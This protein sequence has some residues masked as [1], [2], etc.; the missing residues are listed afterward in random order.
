MWQ[1]LTL[2]SIFLTTSENIIDKVVMVTDKAMDTLLASFYRNGLVF[3]FSVALA[4]TGIFGQLHIFLNWVV[5]LL[6]VL[7]IGQGIFYTYLLKHIELTGSSA[8]SYITPFFFL[9]VD[10][11]ALK[12]P[13]TLLQMGGVVLLVLGGMIFAIS[14]ENWRFKPEYTKYVL[15]I[16]A[17][18]AVFDGCEYYAFKHYHAALGINEISWMASVW[19]LVTA[20][21]IILI[22]LKRGWS[23]WRYTAVHNSY[24]AKEGV[25]KFLDALAY[26]LWLRALTLTNV[27]RVNAL[28]SFEP[29]MLLVMLYATQKLLRK[30][31]DEN[32]DGR[33]LWQK[34]FA[35]AVLILGAL[36]AS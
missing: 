12:A 4:V 8:L 14:T 11:L 15:A 23:K 2:A 35:T 24:I 22:T 6:S 16:F 31:T 28:G 3:L 33:N 9:L 19:L 7:W 21:F 27:S 10:V 1:L 34:I 30:Q 18:N 13:I 17:L 25:A 20:G 29:L 5:L 32:F 36:L 26:L